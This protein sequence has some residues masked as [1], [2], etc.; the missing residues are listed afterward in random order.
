VPVATAAFPALAAA[1]SRGDHDEFAG[2]LSAAARAVTL[3]SLLGAAMLVAAAPPIARVFLA[4]TRVTSE[5]L[6]WGIVGFAPGLVG[7]A[8]VALLTRALYAG[9]HTKVVTLA[10]MA[11]W[12][13]VIGADVALARVLDPARRIA[14]L[15][16]GN[17]IG[18]TVAGVLL[19]ALAATRVPKGSFDRLGRTVVVGMVAAAF[20]GA[21]GSVVATLTAPTSRLLAA[22]LTLLVA[23]VVAV[24][25]GAVVL[26]GLPAEARAVGDI[27]RRQLAGVRAGIK[28]SR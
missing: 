13:V 12:L 28:V 11:G 8:Y 25:Y 17:T 7:Y 27:L 6:A 9:H 22:G 26:V 5:T 15:G 23:V 2:R 24:V 20:G 19:L 14:A 16:W 18:M 1:W 4:H 21:A 10:G 3:L